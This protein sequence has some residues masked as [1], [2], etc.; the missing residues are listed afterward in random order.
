MDQL[1]AGNARPQSVPAAIATGIS[2]AVQQMQRH[3]TSDSQA[4][5]PK[6]LQR[7]RG[8]PRLSLISLLVVQSTP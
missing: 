7:L 5:A 3:A 1:A 8:C 2:Q 6:P 4:C